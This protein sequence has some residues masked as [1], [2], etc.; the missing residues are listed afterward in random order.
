MR[1]EAGVAYV[2][3]LLA[4]AVTSAT[5]AAAVQIGAVTARREAETHLLA[6]GGEFERALRSYSGAPSGAGSAS[7]G[8][9]PRSLDDLLRDPRAP[10]VRRHLRQI[11]ADPLTGKSEWGLIRDSLGSIVGVHS[12]AAGR[13]I[14]Q[15]PTG[16]PVPLPEQADSYRDWV[17]GIAPSPPPK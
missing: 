15:N 12:L 11:Y 3:L 2:L 9:G 4:I 6:I 17:F 16:S 14:R 13:P 1:R 7:A 5:A 10:G 8:R